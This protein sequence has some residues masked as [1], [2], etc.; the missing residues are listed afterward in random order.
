MKQ[1]DKSKIIEV[2]FDLG[3]LRD[4]V[5]TTSRKSLII[6]IEKIAERLVEVVKN[7]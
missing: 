2:I 3:H 1:K 4:N 7:G 6:E 5:Q